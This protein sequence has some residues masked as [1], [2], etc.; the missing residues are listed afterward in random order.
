MGAKARLDM[1]SHAQISHDFAA[2][3]KKDNSFS[4]VLDPRT[5]ATIAIGGILLHLIARYILGAPAPA[6]QS[7]LVAVLILGGLPLLLSLARKLMAHE[8]GSDHLAGISIITSVLL[9]EYLVGAIVIL[10]LSGGAALE[11]FASRRAS[12]VLDALARRMPQVAHR[13]TGSN[14]SDVKL[15]DIGVGDTLVVFPHEICPVDGVVIEGNGKMNEAYLTG[16]PFEIEKVPGSQV[17][18]GAING[19]WQCRFALKSWQWILASREL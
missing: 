14:V 12:S 15:G 10:M 1:A 4:F 9:D 2:P 17:I 6:W 7:P 18:S 19:M 16:E 11:Q 5:T 8:F 13:R 3:P